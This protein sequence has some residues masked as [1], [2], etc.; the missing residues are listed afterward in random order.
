MIREAGGGGGEPRDVLRSWIYID[1]QGPNR[2]LLFQLASTDDGGAKD[3]CTCN[4]DS[5]STTENRSYT[6]RLP[7]HCCVNMCVGQR[8]YATSDEHSSPP[9]QRARGRRRILHRMITFK[10]VHHNGPAWGAE[11]A[12]DI[13]LRGNAL[14]FD[15]FP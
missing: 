3:G 10:G 1:R 5:Y 6:T 14:D 4:V 7:F 12:R 8:G 11:H 13:A 15:M 9:H 2:L